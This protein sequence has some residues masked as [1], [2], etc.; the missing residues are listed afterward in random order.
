MSKYLIPWKKWVCALCPNWLMRRR[1]LSHG[2]KLC[3]ARLAQY[4]GKNGVCR[5][6][7]A[8]LAMQLGVGERQPEEQ[9]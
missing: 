3:Y 6:K 9:V 1:E 4:S 2:A 8:T 7:L 5:P